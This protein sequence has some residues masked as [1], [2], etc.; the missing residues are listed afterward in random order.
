MWLLPQ[1]HAFQ[2]SLTSDM[3]KASALRRPR[4][5]PGPLSSALGGP[6]AAV[7]QVAE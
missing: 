3:N 2:N 1:V 4:P 7:C 5:A 6:W